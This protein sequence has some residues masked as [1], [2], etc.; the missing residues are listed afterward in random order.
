MELGFNQS[1]FYATEGQ[2][3][4]VDACVE[5]TSGILQRNVTVLVTTINKD[6]GGI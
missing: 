5:I 4:A 2:S 3:D 6:H 1:I